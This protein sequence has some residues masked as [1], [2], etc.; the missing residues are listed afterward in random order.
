SR[1][2]VVSLT[3]WLTQ[4]PVGNLPVKTDPD[5]PQAQRVGTRP[6]LRRRPRRPRSEPRRR[7]AEQRS[8]TGGPPP[9]RALLAGRGRTESHRRAS[10]CASIP[11]SLVHWHLPLWP[12]PME[13]SWV[14]R[15]HLG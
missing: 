8:Q 12:G 4:P 9:L 11:V 1:G 3:R 7:A 5:Q 10:T 13:A 2:V 14:T 15:R 6:F